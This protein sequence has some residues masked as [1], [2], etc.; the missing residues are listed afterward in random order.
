[1]PRKT[2]GPNKMKK[3]MKN[4]AKTWIPMKANWAGWTFLSE[5]QSEDG[6]SASGM[7]LNSATRMKITSRS[8][9]IRNQTLN[10]CRQYQVRRRETTSSFLS[11]SSAP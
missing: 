9:A 10:L 7:P 11:S 8:T 5:F 1:M 4:S 6:A 3:L 2:I